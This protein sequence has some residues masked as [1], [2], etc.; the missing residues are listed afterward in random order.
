VSP[1]VS[2]HK[3]GAGVSGST[4]NMGAERRRSLEITKTHKPSSVN[5]AV[6][7]I[8]GLVGKHSAKPIILIDEFD[9]VSTRSEQAHFAE[10]IKQ[11]SD[12]HVSV[13]FIFCG[14]GESIDDLMKAHSSVNRYLH[15]IKLD[16]LAWDPRI[17]IVERAAN[18]LGIS[19]DRTKRCGFVGSAMAFHTTF[20]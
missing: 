18:V 17:E 15:P 3:I 19:I 11:V 5:E 8:A 1:A 2:D 4:F 10:F 12:Q 13:H 9:K 20:T 14:V 6:G 7:M 16:R